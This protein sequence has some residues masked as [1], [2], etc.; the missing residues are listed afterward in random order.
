MLK[1]EILLGILIFVL[2]LIIVPKPFSFSQT[3][4]D[5]GRA[6]NYKSGWCAGIIFPFQ[7]SINFEQ[8]NSTC[9][10][11]KKGWKCIGVVLFEKNY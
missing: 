11:L 3:S 4:D 7:E 9:T 6:N 5:C 2:I 1:K 10:I 8:M